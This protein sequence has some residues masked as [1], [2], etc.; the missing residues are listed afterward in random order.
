MST[1][2]R[3]SPVWSVYI[4]QEEGAPPLVVVDARRDLQHETSA[5]GGRPLPQRVF[6]VYM[7]TI[8]ILNPVSADKTK[9]D[10]RVMLREPHYFTDD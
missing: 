9:G 3:Y 5:F 7:N 4:E 2:V 1:L 8:T 6:V 10:R